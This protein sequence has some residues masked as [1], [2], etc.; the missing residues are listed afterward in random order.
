MKF[1]RVLGAGARITLATSAGDTLD[2]APAG[3]PLATIQAEL[4]QPVAQPL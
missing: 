4:A 3:T 2:L 1:G